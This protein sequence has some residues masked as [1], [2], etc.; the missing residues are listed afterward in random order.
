MSEDLD[1]LRREYALMLEN[2][3]AVQTRCNVLLEETREA[4]SELASLG[5]LADAA[6]ELGADERRVLVAIAR[7]LAVGRKCYG[8]L[9]VQGD[10]R[11]W[12]H[13]AAQEALDC[14]VYLACETMRGAP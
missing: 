9:D 12:R 4:R 3:T 14:A 8:V 11:D 2:L 10:P 7:R 1:R 5:E 13:E 6:R